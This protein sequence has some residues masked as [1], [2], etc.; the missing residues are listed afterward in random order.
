MDER[1]GAMWGRG[2]LGQLRGWRP[3]SGGIGTPGPHRGGLG[4]GLDPH[5]AALYTPPSPYNPGGWQPNEQEIAEW[6]SG[7]D[8]NI[9]A[10]AAA[11]PSTT[12]FKQ[13][14]HASFPVPLPL[15]LSIIS[16][17]LPD[18]AWSSTLV[19]YRVTVGVGRAAG[20]FEFEDKRVSGTANGQLGGTLMLA[21]RTIQVEAALRSPGLT[22][23]EAARAYACVAFIV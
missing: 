1:D 8:F 16:A 13:L 14:L 9:D 23:A 10:N 6:G 20:V 3:Q 17:P 2:W 4:A 11:A 21:G 15:Y 22:P 18:V 7:A 12:E 19:V 5:A